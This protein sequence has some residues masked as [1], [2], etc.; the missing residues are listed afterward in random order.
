MLYDSRSAA[1]ETVGS[2][3][4]G[5]GYLVEAYIWLH[6]PAHS[7]YRLLLLAALK[8]VPCQHVNLSENGNPH[9]AMFPVHLLDR[10]C[11]F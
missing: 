10:C 4:F 8:F 2:I 11:C 9:V 5:D 6:I 3:T 1:L 7:F